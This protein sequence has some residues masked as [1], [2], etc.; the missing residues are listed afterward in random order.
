[1]ASFRTQKAASL[2][3]YLSY[4]SRRT[5]P[6]ETLIELLWPECDLDVGRHRLNVTLSSLRRELIAPGLAGAVFVADHF[7]V[8]LNPAVVSTDVAEFE[9]R[10]SAGLQRTPA[11]AEDADQQARL[12][13]EAAELYRG[14]LLPGFYDD[15]VLPEQQR[16]EE[17]LFQALHRLIALLTQAGEIDRA[18]PF[19][20]RAVAADPL[21]EESHRELIRLYAAAGQ[22][23]AA[24]RQ[25]Q[26]LERIL[27]QELDAVPDAATRALVEGIRSSGVQVF[28]CS[29]V[30]GTTDA[31][32]AGRT[33]EHLNTR[34]PEHPDPFTPSSPLEP[35]GGAVPL[36]S[37]FYV[38]R[39]TD[40]AFRAALTQ[41]R[42]IV[43]L[44]GAGQV[45]KTSLL[46][47]GL[48]HARE[49][50]ARVILTDL[51]KLNAAHLE[52]AESFCRGLAQWLAD[53]LDLDVSPDEVWHPRRGPSA[54]LDQYVQRGVLG[55]IEG[56]LVWG[57]DEV[58][59]LFACEFGSEIFR[60]FRAWHNERALDPAGPWRR[61]TV[62][63][64]YATEAHLFITDANQSP[65]NVGTRLT[66]DDFTPD[67]VA[68][69]NRRYGSP[70]TSEGELRRLHGWV[71]GHPYLVRLCLHELATRGIGMGDLE[72]RIGEDDG[73]FEDHLRRL[74]GR[75][76]R[77]PELCEVLRGALR[78]QPCPTP[79]SFY[80]LRSAG[81]LVGDSARD[82]RLRCRLYAEFLARRLL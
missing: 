7:S 77:D 17:L 80:R 56:P 16:L 54:N 36:D 55:R 28:R 34:T 37:P 61:F 69:L 30:Q 4:H 64:A 47:R 33:P 65:F 73:P 15:W 22:P 26:E 46:A 21:R 53:E 75:L 42:S 12:L 60:L 39:P 45:G 79:E 78:G 59:R 41:R 81:V 14:P 31:T 2:L 24:L 27:K 48:Q 67:Q 25:Y 18:L 40:E 10:V 76:Q 52:G 70:L 6:R 44:K 32:E 43:L 3:A 8:G 13:T 74:L 50:G 63:I 66:L 58:D 35:P 38:E 19:A 5:H 20:L 72:A 23:A 71:S 57:L 51:Q 29:G 49:A 1:V 82:A 62:A 11:P 9:A 68:D